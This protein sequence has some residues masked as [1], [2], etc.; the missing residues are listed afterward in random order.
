MM[1]VR[2]VLIN[3][4]ALTS[5]PLFDTPSARQAIAMNIMEGA[6]DKLIA[7]ASQKLNSSR[8]DY[9]HGIQPLELD[10]DGV[11]LVLAGALPNM[12]EHGWDARQL[13]ETLLH[14]PGVDHSKIYTAEDGSK[15]RFIPFRHKTPG[16]GSDLSGVRMG[17]AY[18]VRGAA[19]LAQ[20]HT[21]VK[22]TKALGRRVHKAAKQLAG[23]EGM[24]AGLAPKL[25]AHHATDIYA[26]MR[27]NKQAVSAPGGGGKAAFQR[28]YTSFRAISDKQESPHWFHPGIKAREFFDDT[29]AY[30]E[31]VAQAAVAAYI[32]AG[33]RS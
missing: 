9:I 24:Q 21:L 10:N 20:P 7:L 27:V 1:R 3:A 18:G 26:G 6:R 28:T 25:R 29:Q 16:A 4:S 32:D 17:A 11:A 2:A 14:G 23:R 13:Q 22:D 31:K 33:M 5:L 19:S 12:V 30:V 15:Y 8:A